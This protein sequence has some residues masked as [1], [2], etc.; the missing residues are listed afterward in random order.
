MAL[1]DPPVPV[2]PPHPEGKDRRG[3]LSHL[4]IVEPQA[5]KQAEPVTR[6][7][8]QKVLGKSQHCAGFRFDPVQSQWWWPQR[9]LHHSTF[10]FRWLRTQRER[11]CK[12]HSITD[13]RVPLKADPSK[14]TT[15]KSFQIYG[16]PSQEGRLQIN[17]DNEDYSKYLTL[18]Y[19]DAE[20]HLLES[21]PSR[22]T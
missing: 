3:W 12:N 16:K 18:K 21:T 5:L 20:E 6:E 17:P 7:W 10:S 13:L 8:L 4:L 22:K 11:L 15:P 9:C 1:L 19:P 2:G 14:I